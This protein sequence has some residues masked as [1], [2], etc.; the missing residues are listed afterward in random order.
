MSTKDWKD[1]T[2]T[3]QTSFNDGFEEIPDSKMPLVLVTIGLVVVVNIMVWLIE[4]GVI[5]L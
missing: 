5:T 3:K 1:I 4:S 2:G